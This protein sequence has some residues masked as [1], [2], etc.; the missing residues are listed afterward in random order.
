MNFSLTQLMYLTAVDTHRNFVKAAESC[1]VTQPTL[2]MQIQKM[3]ENLG[4]RIFDRSRLPVVPTQVGEEIISQARIVLNEAG[5]IEDLIQ[6]MKGEVSGDLRIGIVS[7][8][9]PSIVPLFAP[10]LVKKHT[11]INITIVENTTKVL[12]EM[13]KIE[14]IDCALLAGPIENEDDF[15]SESLFYEGFVAYCHP[16]SEYFLKNQIKPEDIKLKDVWLLRDGHCLKTQV[17]DLCKKSEDESTGRIEYE[18]GSLDSLIRMVDRN[19]GMTILPELMVKDLS[20]KRKEKIRT[21]SGIIPSRHIKLYT[22]RAFPKETLINA[23]I[24]SILEYIPI[25]LKSKKDRKIQKAF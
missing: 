7:T 5:K 20:D 25:A 6:R 23:L 3:E 13:L 10:N 19:K 22:H 12:V 4:I 21:F 14:E 2:S 11:K 15:F 16:T 1:H 17:L 8:L 18:S 9:A 24:S